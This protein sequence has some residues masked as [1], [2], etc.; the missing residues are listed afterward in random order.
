M[1]D[2][3]L[4]AIHPS[5]REVAVLQESTEMILSS[6]DVESVLHQILLIVRNYFGTANCAIF[7][8]DPATQKLY[9][10]AQNG[11]RD[12]SIQNL[13]LAIGKDGISGWVAYT[14]MPYYAPDVR[15]EPRYLMADE[16]VRSELG[17]PLLVRDEVI[18]VLSIG[19][20][21]PDYFNDSMIG[22]L[23]LFAS[24]AAVAVENAR[25]YSSERRRMRQIELINLIA[26][27]ATAANDVEQLLTNLADLID[28]TFDASDVCIL[29]RDRDGKLVMRAYAGIN[30]NLPE[31]FSASERSGIIAAAFA[32][33]TNVVANDIADRPGW[34]SCFRGAG[35]ELCVPLLSLGETLGA[36]I[37]SHPS[38]QFFS[39]DDRSISQAAAD[40]CA[41]AIRNV[42]LAD[43]LRRITNTDSLTGLYNQRYFHVLAAQE[44]ARSRRYHKHFSVLMMALEAPRQGNGRQAFERSD[45]LLRQVALAL[46][47]QMRSVDSICRYGERFAFVLPETSRQRVDGVIQKVRDSLAEVA[48]LGQTAAVPLKPVFAA[49]TFPEDGTS[50]LEIVRAVLNRMGEVESS[51]AA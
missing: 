50:E 29:L 24:Q 1:A 22:L 12:E 30:Q 14:K 26:R 23:A 27:S 44:T 41:T 36:L 33:R 20:E 39:A 46:K 48:L 47:R 49:A 43:E 4:K 6:M 51:S 32:G 35:S 11:F 7:L 16:R 45:E 19:S 8:V 5:I 42:Q 13:R 40:V 9:C 31:D 25:L 37:I 21:H 34:P 28:D 2:S 10:R 15:K 17:L 38:A 18:G 3:P